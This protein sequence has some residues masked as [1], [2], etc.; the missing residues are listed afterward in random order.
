MLLLKFYALGRITDILYQYFDVRLP[1]LM[2]AQ[3]ILLGMNSRLCLT[4][5][6]GHTVTHENVTKINFQEAHSKFLKLGRL[7]KGI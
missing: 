7:T 4:L 2:D 5:Q 1:Y 3:G 6:Y